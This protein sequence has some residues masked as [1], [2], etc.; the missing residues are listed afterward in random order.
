MM[1]NYGET[2]IF[3]ENGDMNVRNNEK[4]TR[5]LEEESSKTQIVPLC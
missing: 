1:C 4:T 5:R 3:M 2:T